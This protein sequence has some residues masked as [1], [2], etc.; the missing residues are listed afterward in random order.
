MKAFK[1][2]EVSNDSSGLGMYKSNDWTVTN[3]K[4]RTDVLWEKIFHEV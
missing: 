1:N 3:R 4:R 2:G